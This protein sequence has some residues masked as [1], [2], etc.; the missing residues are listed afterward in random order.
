[1]PAQQI[2]QPGGAGLG[3]AEAGDRIDGHGPPPVGVQVA[4]LAGGPDDLGRRAGTPNR[5]TKTALKGSAW[6]SWARAAG[7]GMVPR[8]ARAPGRSP[9]APTAPTAATSTASSAA[10]PTVPAG[11][12][13]PNALL[14]GHLL[15]T[16]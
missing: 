5:L 4:G 6:L 16:G 10:T 15:L 2:S 12:G 1:V 14:E 7:S 11:P 9:A 13:A 8:Q 3:G